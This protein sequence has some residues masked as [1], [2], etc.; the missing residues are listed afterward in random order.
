VDDEGEEP[1]LKGLEHL[2]QAAFVSIDEHELIQQLRRANGLSGEP[3]IF[4]FSVCEG[5]DVVACDSCTG[6]RRRSVFAEPDGKDGPD[7]FGKRPANRKPE[8]RAQESQKR[9]VA[10]HVIHP[11]LIVVV[12]LSLS[13][14][15]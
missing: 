3:G 1:L 2:D 7:V 15:L 9:G 13:A 6:E 11:C 10:S 5:F 8:S 4:Y 14:P 12:R